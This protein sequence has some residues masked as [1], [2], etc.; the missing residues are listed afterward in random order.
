MVAVLE[1]SIYPRNSCTSGTA[2]KRYHTVGKGGTH[3]PDFTSVAPVVPPGSQSLREVFCCHL[4]ERGLPSS[5]KLC[6]ASEIH[7]HYSGSRTCTPVSCTWE[8]ISLN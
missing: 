2:P 6:C 8:M 1:L 7:P 4:K 5:A 3:A